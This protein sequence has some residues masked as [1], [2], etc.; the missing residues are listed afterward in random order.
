[1]PFFSNGWECHLSQ[2]V[3]GQIYTT[4]QELT[5]PSASVFSETFGGERGVS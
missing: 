3:T 2:G 5:T 1:M 4:G